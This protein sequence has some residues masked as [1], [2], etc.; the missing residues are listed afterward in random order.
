MGLQVGSVADL[1]LGIQ[2]P[3]SEKRQSGARLARLPS[4][5][6]II[7]ARGR[8]PL[9]TSHSRNTWM[10]ALVTGGAGFIG[11]NLVDALVEAGHEVVVADDLSTGREQNVNAGAE[12]ARVDV[13]T[14]EHE[15]LVVDFAPEVVFHLAAQIDV[16]KS[17]ADPSFDAEVNVVGTVRTAAAAARAGCKVFVFSSSGGTVYGE[18]RDFPADEGHPTK[19]ISPYGVAKLCAEIYLGMFSRSAGM[20]AVAL[21]YANVYGPRQDPLGE[22]GVVAI[23]CNRILDGKGVTIYGDGKQTRDFVYVGDVVRAN[24]CALAATGIR[25]S[26]NIGTGRE[27]DVNTLARLLG[28]PKLSIDYQPA[29]PGETLRSVLDCSR[30]ELDLGWKPEVTVEVGLRRTLEWARTHPEL[31]N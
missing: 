24:L 23:F 9:P 18:Q 30:A 6:Q 21:R 27:T 31:Q 3:A 28:G 17:V 10:R 8:I 22:A 13:T 29:R 14:A 12:L 5:W 16:R 19:P 15:R 2:K 7:V 4:I 1:N 11:S 26:F 20:R 25:G